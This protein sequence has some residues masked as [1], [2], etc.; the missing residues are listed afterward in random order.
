MGK[1]VDFFLISGI[2]F[3]FSILYLNTREIENSP[4]FILMCLLS[5]CFTV[6]CIVQQSTFSESRHSPFFNNCRFYTNDV[7][8]V[9]ASPSGRGS[10]VEYW[11]SIREVQVRFPPLI[12]VFPG[13]FLSHTRQISGWYLQIGPSRPLPHIPPLSRPVP[14]MLK[15]LKF[16]FNS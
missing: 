8:L 9:I 14:K 3:H 15:G 1:F 5:K 10:M 11:L 12:E 13:F 16:K 2:Y 4:I 6:F 7:I